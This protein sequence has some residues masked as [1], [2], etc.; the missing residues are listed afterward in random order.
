MALNFVVNYEEGGEYCLLDGD[1]HSESRLVDIVGTQRLA[2]ARNFN[3]ESVYEFG[4]RVGVWRIFGEFG[5]RGLP[6]TVYAV[7]LALEKN[8]EVG[9]YIRGRPE[10][11]VVAHGWRW[12]DYHAISAEEE[13]RQIKRCSDAI[14]RATGTRPIGWYCG[15]PSINTRRLV[16]ESGSF[17]YDCDAYNDDLPYWTDVCDRPF[18][19]IPHT[20]D[21]NDTRLSMDMGDHSVEDWLSYLCGA[22]EYCRQEGSRFPR[23]LTIGLHCRI[24][25]RPGRMWALSR[26]L[27]HAQKLDDIWICSRDSLA[28]HW[29][30]EHPHPIG[31]A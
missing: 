8:P 3:A 16:K 21:A 7:G 11:D 26:L 18:L 31:A 12:I 27:D 17:L 14:E 13:A 28:R 20:L 2:G 10:I 6:F 4:S 5:R 29:I 23:M 19:V 15:R 9:S 24:I 25:G 22:I 30:A 1:D